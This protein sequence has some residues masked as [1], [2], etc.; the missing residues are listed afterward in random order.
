MASSGSPAFSFDADAVAELSPGHGCATAAMHVKAGMATRTMSIVQQLAAAVRD[1]LFAAKPAVGPHAGARSGIL[2]LRQLSQMS[3]QQLDSLTQ[4]VKGL[5]STSGGRLKIGTMCS[6]SDLMVP[7]FKQLWARISQY[8]ELLAAEVEHLFAVEVDQQKQRWILENGSPT[9]LFKDITL[10]GEQTGMDLCSQQEVSIPRCDIVY[11]GFSCEAFSFLNQN[12]ANSEYANALRDR[13]G[14]SGR[15][16]GG[17]V[18]YARV[19][20]PT[21]I[22]IENVPSL[23]AGKQGERNLEELGNM[24][25][26]D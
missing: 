5:V 2:A 20:R 9:F 25:H 11:V 26:G 16:F 13:A 18:E 3:V 10:M 12:R 14:S 24:A 6:G 7:V 17:L 1:H 4:G 21:L 19:H 8:C 22:I 15:T 23:M